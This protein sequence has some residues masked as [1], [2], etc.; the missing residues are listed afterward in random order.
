MTLG[1][2]ARYESWNVDG[3]SYSQNYAY[4]LTYN[5]KVI[6]VLHIHYNTN[7]AS[8]IKTATIGLVKIKRTHMSRDVLAY[9]ASSGLIAAGRAKH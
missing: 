2:P 3:A 4:N 6:G 8:D 5:G 9:G 1:A 7:N